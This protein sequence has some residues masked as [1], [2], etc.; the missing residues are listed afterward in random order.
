MCFV[1]SS[2]SS[3]LG[4]IQPPGQFHEVYTPVPTVSTGG[5]FYSLDTMHLTE[6]IKKYDLDTDGVNTNHDHPSTT[7]TLAM[8]LNSVKL[9]DRNG[10]CQASQASSMPSS[11][12]SNFRISSQVAGRTLSNGP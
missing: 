8:M 9:L 2:V 11:S 7:M 3:R 5:H 4:S 10:K 1:A 12:L 6:V